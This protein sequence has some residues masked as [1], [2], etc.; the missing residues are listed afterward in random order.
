M[1][2]GDDAKI[3]PSHEIN[4]QGKNFTESLHPGEFSATVEQADNCTATSCEGI[5]IFWMVANSRTL[6]LMHYFW[7]RATHNGLHEDSNQAFIVDVVY[8]ECTCGN[9]TLTT[10]IESVNITSTTTEIPS[11]NTTSNEQSDTTVT[12]NSGSQNLIFTRFLVYF[13]SVCLF[14]W[15]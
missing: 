2:I 4:A 10:T 9:Q 8:P 12:T 11:I 14:M 5:G 7:C 6:L 15:M 13:F 3:F 1:F